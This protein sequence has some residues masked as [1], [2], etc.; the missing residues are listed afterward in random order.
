MPQRN[1]RS[2]PYHPPT[3]H[4]RGIPNPAPRIPLQRKRLSPALFSII[5]DGSPDS[6]FACTPI[7]ESQKNASIPQAKHVSRMLS[8]FRDASERRPSKSV[9]FGSIDIDTAG[10]S[11]ASGLPKS[12]EVPGSSEPAAVPKILDIRLVCLGPA[13]R[14]SEGPGSP[15]VRA[16]E[17]ITRIY[18]RR[19]QRI[20]GVGSHGKKPIISAD[21]RSVRNDPPSV[22]RIRKHSG[23]FPTV[24]CIGGYKD[25]RAEEPFSV[26][27]PRWSFGARRLPQGAAAADNK[28]V[29]IRGYAHGVVV[30]H[31]V[32]QVAGY[33]ASHAPAFS[34]V[35]TDP[36][37]D[38]ARNASVS[39]LIVPRGNDFSIREQ[40]NLRPQTCVASHHHVVEDLGADGDYPTLFH[41]SQYNGLPGK[42]GE[43]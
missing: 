37:R 5:T 3:A 25:H 23:L 41:P 35:P 19:R 6:K 33:Q 42:R 40:G 32:R 21:D 31:G 24:P 2:Q 12:A 14:R 13:D 4:L 7:S 11:I 16:L 29:A 38:I 43:Y 18:P 8:V 28:Q 39:R 10:D 1:R 34:P 30:P 27:A 22:G 26:N 20:E 17:K 15:G 36:E 9:I